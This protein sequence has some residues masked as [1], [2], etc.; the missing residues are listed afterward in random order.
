MAPNIHR[1]MQTLLASLSG[2]PMAMLRGIA[3]L[4]ALALAT[5]HRDEAAAQLAAALVEP[6][7]T[8]AALAACSDAARAAW[9]ALVAA[10]GRLKT[11]VFTRQHGIIRPVGPGRME[12][13]ATW[14]QPASPAEELWY[15]GLIFRGFADLG[16]GPAEYIYIPNE[17][18]PAT[19]PAAATVAV[20]LA[21][22]EAPVRQKYAYNTLAVDICSLLA[23]LRERPL[24][25]A[26]S[27]QPRPADLLP[28]RE[29]ALLRDPV[30]FDLALALARQQGWLAVDRDRLVV[31]TQQTTAWL[32]STPWEQMRTL[33]EAW[34][35]STDVGSAQHY[36]WNDLRRIPSLQAEGAWRN[37]PLLARRAILTALNQLETGPWYAI[38]EF[39]AW[40]KQTAPDFQRPD[41]SYTGWYLREVATGRYLSGFES[42]DEVEGRLI[43]F[44]LTGPLFWL[45]ALALGEGA[46]GQIQTFRLTPLGAAW[47]GRPLPEHLP[48]PA[49]LSVDEQFIVTAP[50]LL[51]LFDRFR[52]LRFTEPIAEPYEPGRPTRH[53]ITRGG[54]ARARAAGVRGRAI[55]E[56]LRRAS[57]DRLPPRV[58]TALARWEEHGGAVTITRGAVLRVEDASILAALRADPTLAPLLGDLLSAQAVL[59]RERDLPQ[60]LKALDELGY[61]VRTV[62]SPDPT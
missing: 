9:A 32:R 43:R 48:R 19:L 23:I 34:R 27:G 6:E 36:G 7:A 40:I 17:L 45:A 53:R 16:D 41:G 50:L 5:N 11:P 61:T 62:S 33:Y 14:R 59:V 58:A 18:L 13:E 47:L 52:L 3:E 35:D 10:G 49:H 31:N 30:R 28:L 22:R 12:R 51:P 15:R 57:G 20:G 54:L 21:P 8:A 29:T 26:R 42:W 46:D 55:I 24:R 2:H 56:F 1:T 39:V 44:I 60:L 37:D 38:N 25:V 4:R